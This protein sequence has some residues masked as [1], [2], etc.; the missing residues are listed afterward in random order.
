LNSDLLLDDT[1]T[2]L[3]WKY[4]MVTAD[5]EVIGSQWRHPIQ[6]F[7]EGWQKPVQI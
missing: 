5:D 4:S 1:G 2:G 7:L 6:H 3:S